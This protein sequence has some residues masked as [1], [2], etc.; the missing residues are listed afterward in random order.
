MNLLNIIY[1]FAFNL[2]YTRANV[3]IAILFVDF[4]LGSNS[5]ILGSFGTFLAHIGGFILNNLPNQFGSNLSTFFTFLWSVS[6]T[7]EKI[8]RSLSFSLTW[9]LVQEVTFEAVLAHF[10]HILEKSF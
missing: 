8:L 7:G 2:T 10:K 1:V 6:P 3:E 5:D 9:F 4:F